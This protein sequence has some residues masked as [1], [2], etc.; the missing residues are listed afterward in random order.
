MVIAFADLFLSLVYLDQPE[1]R[2]IA[3]LFYED[4]YSQ[5]SKVP[6]S[7]L[8]AVFR[9][10]IRIE[11]TRDDRHSYYFCLVKPAAPTERIAVDV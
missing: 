8:L 6:S 10:R 9:I 2:P 3:V 5:T 11:E 1:V 4:G 7:S